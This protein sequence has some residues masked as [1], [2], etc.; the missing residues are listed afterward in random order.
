MCQLS[1]RNRYVSII[2]HN[3]YVPIIDH[4]TYVPI[5]DHNTYVP[6]I[7]SN[8]CD[9]KQSMIND[10]QKLSLVVLVLLEYKYILK[11]NRLLTLQISNTIQ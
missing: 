11:K 6:I 9:N 7:D 3:R 4:N 1:V 10:V 2:N 5:I 8:T